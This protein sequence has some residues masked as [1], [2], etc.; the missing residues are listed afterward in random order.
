MFA[1]I[2]VQGSCWQWQNGR[3]KTGKEGWARDKRLLVNSERDGKPCLDLRHVKDGL[4][5]I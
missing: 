5:L 1:I 2:R 3:F 4:H